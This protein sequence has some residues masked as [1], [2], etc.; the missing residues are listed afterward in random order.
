MVSPLKNVLTLLRDRPPEEDENNEM[1]SKIIITIP[2]GFDDKDV[3]FM[4]GGWNVRLHPD[5]TYSTKKN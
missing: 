4:M 3:T 2:N 1:I 5:G